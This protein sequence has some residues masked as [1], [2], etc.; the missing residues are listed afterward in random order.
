[1]RCDTFNIDIVQFWPGS[2]DVTLRLGSDTEILFHAS[3][4]GQEPLSSMFDTFLL[5][6]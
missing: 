5:A 1:M 2:E 6:S 4:V 3:Y